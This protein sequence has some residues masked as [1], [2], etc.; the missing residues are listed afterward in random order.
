M[1][2]GNLAILVDAKTE[3]TKQLI[4]IISPVIYQGVKLIY[5][6]A[7]NKSIENEESNSCLSYFQRELSEIPKWNQMVITEK[8]QKVIEYSKCDWLEDLLTAV[9]V[10]HTKIL[11]SI[12]T[13]KNKNKINLQIP[14]VDFFIHQCYIEVAREFWKNPYLFDDS[15]NNFEYQRN[16]RDA[17]TII[18]NVIGE[19]I[20]RQLPVKNILREYLGNE[21]NEDS[22]DNIESNNQITDNLRK[23]VQTEIENCSKEKLSALNIETSREITDDNTLSKEDIETFNNTDIDAIV[24]QENLNNSVTEQKIIG[25]NGTEIKINKVGENDIQLDNI[26][27]LINSEVDK[28]EL[29]S[30]NDYELNAKDIE[31]NLSKQLNDLSQ[32]EEVYIDELDKSNIENNSGSSSFENNNDSSSFENN[33][34]SSSFENNSGS[35]VENNSSS[36]NSLD[37]NTNQEENIKLEINNIQ[38]SSVNQDSF[39]N[40]D[41][42]LNEN[43]V[44]DTNND[45][46]I[47]ELN[48]DSL[49][50]LDF[51]INNL[52]SVNINSIENNLNQLNSSSSNNDSESNNINVNI[53]NNDSMCNNDVVSNNDENVKTIIIDTKPGGSDRRFD[54][55]RD[56]EI[57]D[58]SPRRKV[59]NKYA[60]KKK[61]D[62]SFFSDAL[63]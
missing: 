49:D 27:D 7:K 13:N 62:F 1:E 43:S 15:V 55:D 56:L 54:S 31:E 12:N 5:N 47:E 26:D 4:N 57:T 61:R 25:E 29:V 35:N 46:D 20:R 37:L 58:D 63:S 53:S 38:D 8:Y 9:F 41:S 60:S 11:T 21:Y 2:D 59:F 6:E 19:T 39:V 36:L 16:R 18:E 48:L 14:K 28:L 42:I 34:G 44:S 30:H 33:I 51:D 52:D 22:N 32:L 45:M 23:L 24:K 3:Y 17:S 50:D 40:Q 10:S